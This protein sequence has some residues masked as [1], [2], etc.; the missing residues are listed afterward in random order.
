MMAKVNQETILL[1]SVSVASQ[2]AFVV[3]SLPL[4]EEVIKLFYYA[5]STD[6]A[7]KDLLK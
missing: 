3:V 2:V 6:T 1:R 4:V 5:K 7:A